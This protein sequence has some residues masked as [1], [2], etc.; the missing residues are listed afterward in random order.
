MEDRERHLEWRAKRWQLAGARRR[1]WES[2]AAMETAELNSCQLDKPIPSPLPESPPKNL[3]Q[4]NSSMDAAAPRHWS[5]SPMSVDYPSPSRPPLSVAAA[6]MDKGSQ[7][8]EGVVLQARAHSGLSSRRAA[9]TGLTVR[10]SSEIC[11]DVGPTDPQRQMGPALRDGRHSCGAVNLPSAIEANR[12]GPRSRTFGSKQ[13]RDEKTHASLEQGGA[14]VDAQG[15]GC[16]GISRPLGWQVTPDARPPLNALPSTSKFPSR[17]SPSSPLADML[18]QSPRPRHARGGE[19]RATSAHGT[20]LNW[21][22]NSNDDSTAGGWDSG[23]NAEWL[24]GVEES[25]VPVSATVDACIVQP[26]ISQY[27]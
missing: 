4:V 9:S 2:I 20:A 18:L 25:L 17:A 16:F 27:R 12:N 5:T 13:A 21:E 6:N 23:A 24:G 26:I 8:D 7:M 11:T 22:L 19:D 1:L 10:F 14:D 15:G 3:R